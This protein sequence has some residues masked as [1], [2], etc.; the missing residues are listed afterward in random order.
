[1]LRRTLEPGV[2]VEATY[3]DF[4]ATPRVPTY[5][6]FT[7]DAG[8]LAAGGPYDVVVGERADGSFTYSPDADGIP[9]ILIP[10]AAPEAPDETPVDDRPGGRRRRP[11]AHRLHGS[12]AA[13]TRFP[14]TRAARTPSCRNPSRRRS[15]LRRSPTAPSSNPRKLFTGRVS[16]VQFM[17]AWCSQCADQSRL[18]VET[19]KRYGD[20]VQ[21]VFVGSDSDD[22]ED[23]Q[24]FLRDNASEVPVVVDPDGSLFQR[25]AVAEPPVTAVIDAGGGIVRMWPGGASQE[26][27]DTELDGLLG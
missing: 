7:M 5:C 12:S 27:L 8:G 15:S 21:V 24:A 23:L 4:E 11:P 25:Y 9:T 3:I 10:E 17:A 2:A 13:P 26:Q 20:D 14:R 1:M 19:A 16:L 22:P 18:V 6:V